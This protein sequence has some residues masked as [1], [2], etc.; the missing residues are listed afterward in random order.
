MNYLIAYCEK[1]KINKLLL[2]VSELNSAANEFYS[3][4]DFRTVGKRKNYYKDGSDALLK[5]KILIKK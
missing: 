4:F 3:H 5:E 2:E 1:L